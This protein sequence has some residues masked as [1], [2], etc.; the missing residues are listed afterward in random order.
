M[1]ERVNLRN[2]SI[3]FYSQFVEKAIRRLFYH[4]DGVDVTN[5]TYIVYKYN[6][7]SLYSSEVCTSFLFWGTEEIL[8]VNLFIGAGAKR[9]TVNATVVCS[10]PTR[11]KELLFINIFSAFCILFVLVTR[12]N[13]GV[14][15]CHSTR[16]ASKIRRCVGNGVS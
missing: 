6:I 13:R 10:I 12:Q 4:V 2:Y 8:E 7:C 9:V 15:F 3:L 16:N 11:G 14:E 1:I 5:C